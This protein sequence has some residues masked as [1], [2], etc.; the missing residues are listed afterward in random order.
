MI[1]DNLW[2]QIA[3]LGTSLGPPPPPRSECHFIIETRD[4]LDLSGWIAL[5]GT[6][7]PP[8]IIYYRLQNA[9]IP[10]LYKNEVMVATCVIRKTES[11]CLE[12][13]VAKPQRQGYGGQLIHETIYELYKRFGPPTLTYVWELTALGLVQAYMKGWLRSMVAMEYG[14][15]YKTKDHTSEIRDLSKPYHTM[16]L[17]FSD[18]GLEDGYIFIERDPETDLLTIDWSKI[19]TKKTLWMQSPVCPGTGWTWTGEFIII[20]NINRRGKPIR[21]VSYLEIS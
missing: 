17:W 16:G 12:T 13:L 1:W 2:T 3:I 9:Y 15:S 8:D 19:R 14:W 20:G 5:V 6:R 21:P 11:F 10:C 7:W 4:S 18:S